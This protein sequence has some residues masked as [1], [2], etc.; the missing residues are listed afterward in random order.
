[1]ARQGQFNPCRSI[2]VEFTCDVF[3]DGEMLGTVQK[4]LILKRRF[5]P[6]PFRDL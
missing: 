1:M 5:I 2:Q 4:V 3:D 6:N